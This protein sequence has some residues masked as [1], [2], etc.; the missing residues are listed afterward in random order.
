MA[1]AHG[2]AGITRIVDAGGQTIG[3][4]LPALDLA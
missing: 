2:A 4:R 3:D 1:Y